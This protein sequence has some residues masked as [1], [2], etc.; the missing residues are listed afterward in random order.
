ML[1]AAVHEIVS[2]NKQRP[3]NLSVCGLE[4]WAGEGPCLK[5]PFV[6]FVRIML[7]LNPLRAKT[8]QG[9][10]ALA[11]GI[12]PRVEPFGRQL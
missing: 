4:P 10:P 5:S 11:E 3:K 8:P 9:L 6:I 7:G 2:S 1:F 12:R